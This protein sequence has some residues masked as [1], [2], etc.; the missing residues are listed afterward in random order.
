ME[1]FI[2]DVYEA[3]KEKVDIITLSD[4]QYC[5]IQDPVDPETGKNRLG[6]GKVVRGEASFFLKPGERLDDG[7]QDIYILGEDEG[8][9]LRAV[10]EHK[11]K[12]TS[13]WT[14]SNRVLP[15]STLWRN[16]LHWFCLSDGEL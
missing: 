14:N 13:V 9:V 10:A 3:I 4:L 5:M 15:K 1:S 8:L 2:P 11:V 6:H 7:I 12:M 16:S